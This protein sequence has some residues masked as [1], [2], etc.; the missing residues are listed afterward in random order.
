MSAPIGIITTHRIVPVVVLDDPADAEPLGA[1]LKAGGLPVAEVTFRT[2]AA[3]ESLRRMALDPE[4]LVGAGTIVRADQVDRAVALGARFVVSPGLSQAVVRRSQELGIPVLPGV[5]TPTEITAALDLGLTIVKL[6][7]AQ[8]LGGVPTVRA[9]SAPFPTLRFI[10]TG[11][12]TAAQLRSYLDLRCV[13]AVGGS[14]M[15]A[16]SLVRAGRFDEVTRLTA[17]AVATAGMVP[18]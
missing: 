1:A 3:E 6:F 4:L 15:V 9:L 7:P 17:E 5:S 14:W 18:A 8:S 10:P 16:T 13:A 2:A 12:I 11:G